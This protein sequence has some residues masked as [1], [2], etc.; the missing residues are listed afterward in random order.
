MATKRIGQEDFGNFLFAFFR[1]IFAR[2]MLFGQAF[3]YYYDIH[4]AALKAEENEDKAI[5]MVKQK[6]IRMGG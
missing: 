3:C 4:D 6:Y 5:E 1:G 2:H